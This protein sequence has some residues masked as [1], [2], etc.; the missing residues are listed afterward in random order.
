MQVYTNVEFHVTSKP[1]WVEE[2]SL[3]NT[4]SNTWVYTYSVAINPDSSP[5]TDVIALCD[6]RGVCSAVMVTQ[7]AR[8]DYYIST[9]YSRD[10]HV[11]TLQQATEGN[12]INIVLMGDAFSDREIAGGTYAAIMNKMMEAFFGE[13][14]YTTLR[15]LFNVYSVDVVS[16]T[17]GYEHDGQ[18]LGGWFEGGGSTSVGG[19][20]NKCMEYAQK[21]IPSSQ[22]SSTLIIVAMNSP[23]YAGTCWMYYPSSGDYGDGLSI[24]YFPLN[25]SDEGLAQL[26]HHEAGG[27][28]F[29]K[30]ADEYAYQALGEMPESQK[31][32]RRKQVPYGWWKNA[33]FTND[34]DE[35]KWSRFLKDD[36]YAGEGLGCFEG[37]FTYWTG[38]WRPTEYS[39]MRYNTGGFN[40][41]SR[42]AIWYRIHKLAYGESWEYDYE[43]FVAYDAV[44]R[45]SAAVARRN[46]QARSVSLK[47]F[48]P[49]APPVVIPHAWNE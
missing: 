30:L 35:V 44:N 46:K 40:A 27:H 3:E 10:G 18:A 41:P 20:D 22:M 17:E 43:A 45:T 7:E 13:E 23:T 14:P 8:P 12:G 4:A 37:A 26:V 19:D 21:I 32:N 2:V 47:G 42:E 24:A 15:P 9:D 25:T 36:R 11:T 1:S 48:R 29:A 34:P 16:E 49:L 33:D 31:E 28:G 39:I 6:A 38:A 5:R